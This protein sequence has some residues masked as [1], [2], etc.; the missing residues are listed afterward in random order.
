MKNLLTPHRG[1]KKISTQNQAV[2]KICRYWDHPKGLSP[3]IC[4]IFTYLFQNEWIQQGYC[5]IQTRGGF[6]QI[7]I[8]IWSIFFSQFEY[9]LARLLMEQGTTATI[10]LYK[11]T[12]LHIRSRVCHVIHIQSKGPNIPKLIHT[13]ILLHNYLVISI[14]LFSNIQAILY[15]RLTH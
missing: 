9:F 6:P 8:C 14:S 7:F 13:H 3:Q 10:N 11:H 2:R 4:I 5:F 1:F 12:L 15:L